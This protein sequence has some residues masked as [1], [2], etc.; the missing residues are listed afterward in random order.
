MDYHNKLNLKL[1]KD[2]NKSYKVCYNSL[3]DMDKVYSN[4]INDIC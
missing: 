4:G 3:N 2:K 1:K